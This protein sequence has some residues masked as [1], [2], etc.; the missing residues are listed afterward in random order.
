M[1]YFGKRP[2]KLRDQTSIDGGSKKID[3]LFK[4]K[5]TSNQGTLMF[6]FKVFLP[7]SSL[8]LPTINREDE[9]K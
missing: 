7:I 4:S 1:K 2:K 9:I 8:P 5:I 6:E 3:F